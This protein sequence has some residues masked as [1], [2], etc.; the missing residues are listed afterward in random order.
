MPKIFFPVRA[1]AYCLES[2]P[3]MIGAGA[4][5]RELFVLSISKTSRVC[6]A[7]GPIKLDFLNNRP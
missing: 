2:D 7:F 4:E 6:T 3:A 5:P 1:Q